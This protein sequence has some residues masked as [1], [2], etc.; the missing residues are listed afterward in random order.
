ML[1]GSVHIRLARSNHL[2]AK[3]KP[4]HLLDEA[5]GLGQGVFVLIR[6]KLEDT[7]QLRHYNDRSQKQGACEATAHNIQDS[8]T[9][10][11]C[12]FFIVYLHWHIGSLSDHSPLLKQILVV[13]P[14]S[15]YPLLQLYVA[16]EPKVV[17]LLRLTTPSGG[18]SNTPQSTTTD[19]KHTHVHVH[20]HT[21]TSP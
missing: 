21:H 16:M 5:V 7:N 10:L 14:S 1:H 18:P 17:P 11:Q 4:H 2:H 13:L 20:E 12:H 6:W 19:C 9:N 3:C 15:R 8:D